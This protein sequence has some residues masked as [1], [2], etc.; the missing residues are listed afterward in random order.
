MQL[1]YQKL[2]KQYFAR[3]STISKNKEYKLM[4]VH[5]INFAFK[6]ICKPVSGSLLLVLHK[7]ES[8]VLIYTERQGLL[9]LLHDNSCFIN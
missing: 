8:T 5:N 3:N 7:R 9:G 4:Y 1:E 2:I 6:L